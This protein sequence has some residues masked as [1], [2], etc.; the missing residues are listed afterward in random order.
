MAELLIR[1]AMVDHLVVTDLLEP[2]PGP[3]RASW[4][5][6][7]TQLVADGHVAEARPALADLARNAGIPYLVD[8][9]TPFLQTGV[10]AEDRW[11]QLPFGQPDPVPPAAI[12]LHSLVKDVVDF[13][14][15]KGATRIIPPYF[16]ASSPSDPWYLLSL[17]LIERTAEYLKAEGV[18][19]PMLPVFCAQLQA[20]GNPAMWGAG[21]D[22]FLAQVSNIEIASVAL[23]L[24]PA[25]AGT[26]GYGKVMRLFDTARRAKKPGIRVIAWRQGIYGPALVAA[27]LDGYECG[28][29]TGEQTNIAR[30]QSSRKPRANGESKGGGGSA[31]IFIETL[32]RSVPRGVGQILLGSTPMRPKVM[33]DDESCCPSIAATLDRSR[34]HAVRSRARLLRQLVDQ[35]HEQWRLN[36]M[37]RQAS[38]AATLAAQANAV[39]QSEEAKNRIEFRNLES[40]A[41]V[42]EHLSHGH[43]GTRSA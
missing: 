37:A 21:I 33:C 23:C 18:R 5:P 10:A 9:D 35:P 32:G 40:L 6:P 7:I 42:A 38:E 4:R 24:S 12:D 43:L 16:Y 1:A 36:A 13:Q 29:G 3:R 11:A 2:G 17:N 8:P 30:Q 39:L 15:D 31:G 20:F 22:R 27:G 14:L 19:L 41:L 34:H 25:G 26:D 28:I